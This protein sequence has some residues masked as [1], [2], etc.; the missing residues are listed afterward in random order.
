MISRQKGSLTIEAAIVLPLILTIIFTMGFLIQIFYVQV[1]V[2]HAI[3][4]TAKEIAAYGYLLDKAGLY[5][6][7]DGVAFASLMDVEDTD[8]TA[9]LNPRTE[10]A[11]GSGYNEMASFL[12]ELGDL[13][14]TLYQAYDEND[15]G[16]PVMSILGDLLLDAVTSMAASELE[17]YLEELD[18]D[19]D[20]YLGELMTRQLIRKYF[21]SPNSVSMEERLEQL[22]I[23]GGLDFR[24]SQFFKPPHA[25]YILLVV[26]YDLDPILPIPILGEMRITQH[27]FVRGWVTA[28]GD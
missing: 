14:F 5:S 4:E 22:N 27:V 11:G 6:P 7:E 26:S 17:N 12:E 9:I 1:V 25:D 21:V 16:A 2:Q 13:A 20:N 28:E 10:V 8:K 23:V 19:L 18:F 15:L 3:N 24:G